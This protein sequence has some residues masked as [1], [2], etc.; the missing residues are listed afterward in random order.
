[1]KEKIKT[2]AF[3]ADDTLWVNEQFYRE[4]EK[5]LCDMLSDYMPAEQVIEEL[6]KTEMQDLEWYGYGIKAFVLSM[7][8]TAFRIPQHLRPLRY[9]YH[10]TGPEYVTNP[11]NCSRV[12]ETRSG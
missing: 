3:D 6:Y 8:D 11:L 10:E 2:I 12:E 9:K 7:I 1:M 5:K 4:A